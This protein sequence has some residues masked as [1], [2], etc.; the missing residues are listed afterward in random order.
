MVLQ[1][2]KFQIITCYFDLLFEYKKQIRF[3]ERYSSWHATGIV[4]YRQ[5]VTGRFFIRKSP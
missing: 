2:M 4:P 1:I 5:L 3:M